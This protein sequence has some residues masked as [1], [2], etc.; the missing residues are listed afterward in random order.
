[1]TD[2]VSFQFTVTNSGNVTIT[3]AVTVTDINIPATVACPASGAV[4]IA[5]GAAVTC[6]ASWTPGAGG[7]RRG[8]LHQLRHSGD[9][10]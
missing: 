2:T 8:Q 1:M 9:H 5:P 10:L 7:H 3:D 4:S 6:T